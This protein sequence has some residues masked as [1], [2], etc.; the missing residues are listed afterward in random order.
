VLHAADTGN[1][2]FAGPSI[3]HTRASVAG[4]R[5]QKARGHKARK[6][7]A[8][9]RAEEAAAVVVAAVGDPS[10]APDDS[11][12]ARTEAAVTGSAALHACEEG[13]T[14]AAKAAAANACEE[15]LTPAA[16]AVVTGCNAPEVPAAYVSSAGSSV[17]H[18]SASPAADK[19]AFPTMLEARHDSAVAACTNTC[20]PGAAA[21]V[22]LNTSE[23]GE[24]ATAPEA[25]VATAGPQ[26]AECGDA[27]DNPTA[28]ARLLLAALRDE[29]ASAAA[30][31]RHL[32]ALSELA[33]E[34]AARAAAACLTVLTATA[35]ATARS[36][37]RRDCGFRGCARR[38]RNPRRAARAKIL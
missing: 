36:K 3:A 22:S 6:G 24:G 19:A 14:T 20:E 8:N 11:A 37:M 2:I 38:S 21:E 25:P 33:R 26:T 1:E 28:A 30:V 10:P 12:A 5:K 16:A 32:A 13:P 34:P 15:G 17:G 18:P 23:P 35:A 31:R 4:G 27:A 7:A 29:G 9:N